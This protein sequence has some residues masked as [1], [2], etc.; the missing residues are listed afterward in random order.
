[1]GHLTRRKLF[2]V[3][4]ACAMPGQVQSNTTKVGDANLIALGQVFDSLAARV[5]VAIDNG[6]DLDCDLLKAF[7]RVHDQI[8]SGQATTMEGLFVKARAAA[9][10]LF[11]DF[12][13]HEQTS[14]ADKMALSIIRD[15]I[16]L[17][18][19]RLERPGALARL[20]REP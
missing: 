1:M 8:L 14:T 13:P 7:G 20:A 6:F 5:D 12:Q 16:R 18:Q 15:L 10:G 4:A 19:P 17:H 3:T 2:A 9:W 11:G